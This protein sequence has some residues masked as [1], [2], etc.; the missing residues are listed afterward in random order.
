M[1]HTD[2]SFFLFFF[3]D[4]PE[5]VPAESAIVN[6]SSISLP[7]LAIEPLRRPEMVGYLAFSCFCQHV[8]GFVT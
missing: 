2:I 5:N 4:V 3:M 6:N 8:R 1:Y 7:D